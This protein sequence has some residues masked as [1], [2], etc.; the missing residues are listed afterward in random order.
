MQLCDT[1]SF[2][3]DCELEAITSDNKNHQKN[4]LKHLHI[5]YP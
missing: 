1:L 5:C 3:C 4:N 2:K